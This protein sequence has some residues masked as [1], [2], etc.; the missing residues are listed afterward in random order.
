MNAVELEGVC[1]S[2]G[3]VQA[4]RD[5]HIAVPTGVVYGFLG[6]NGAGK[7]TTIRMLMN[8]LIP[9]AGRMSILGHPDASRSKDRIGYMPEERGLYNKMRV[10]DLLMY[11]GGIHA[12]GSSELKARIS[13]WLGR[14]GLGGSE[15]RR[16]EEL[17]KGNQQKLQFVGTVLHE[18]EL[19][20]L[21]E[22]FAGLDP[23]NVELMRGLIGEYREQGRTVIFSTHMMEQAE[24]LCDRILLINRGKKV[25]DGT[26]AELQARDEVRSVVIAA[27]D[28]LGF[29]ESLPMVQGAESNGRALEVMLADDHTPQQLLEALVPRARLTRFEVRQASL[30]EIFIHLVGQCD[31]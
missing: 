13:S 28:D 19:L 20:I 16:V 31:A 26:L 3:K 5:L 30:A 2:F 17:S 15:R 21:D 1:K 25:A 24:R 14:V 27:E 11:L 4:V 18:P 7:T 29:V 23:V 22:P 10:A 12:V 9:D 8:I 6:P